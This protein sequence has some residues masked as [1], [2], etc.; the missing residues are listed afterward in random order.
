MKMPEAIGYPCYKTITKEEIA[1]FFTAV[2]L[3]LAGDI[4]EFS[5][6]TMLFI[7]II[8]TMT[9]NSVYHHP[10]LHHLFAAEQIN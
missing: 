7:S 9:L 4:S 2:W 1:T 3:Q 5:A 6:A 10:K 8:K